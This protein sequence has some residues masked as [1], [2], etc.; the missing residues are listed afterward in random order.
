MTMTTTHNLGFP[1]IGAKRE[2]KFTQEAYWKGETTLDELKRLGAHIL[3][4]DIG[5]GRSTIEHMMILEPNQLKIGQSLSQHVSAQPIKRKQLERLVA[6]AKSMGASI[7]ADG[8]KSKEDE[9][10]LLETGVE[11]GQ[12]LIYGSSSAL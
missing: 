2:L 12:G 11:Y 8:V 4:D 5:S 3:L 7:I 6:I 1:R 10:V 9:K